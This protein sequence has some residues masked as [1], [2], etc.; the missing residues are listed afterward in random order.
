M[1]SELKGLALQIAAQL[2]NDRQTALKVLQFAGEVVEW[3]A[4]EGAAA[5]A[6]IRAIRTHEH[7]PRTA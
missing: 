5:T 2:P 3:R 6:E 4:D 1:S 7:P